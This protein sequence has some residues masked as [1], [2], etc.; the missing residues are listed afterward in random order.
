MRGTLRLLTNV[1]LYV[2]ENVKK[3]MSLVLKAWEPIKSFV[4][5]GSRTTHLRK[6]L[7]VYL[8]S[9]EE[10]YKGVV[11]TFVVKFSSM[12]EFKIK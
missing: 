12:K 6:Y 3:M 4:S 5:L 9:D 10:F 1:R 8:E 2:W 11:S 7:Q